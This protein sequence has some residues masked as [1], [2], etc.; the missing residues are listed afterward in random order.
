MNLKILFSML[1]V[2]HLFQFGFVKTANK[3]TKITKDTISAIDHI[4]TN[5]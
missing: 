3:P 5:L 2:G 4:I 1:S